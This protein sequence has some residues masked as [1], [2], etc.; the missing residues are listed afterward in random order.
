MFLISIAVYLIVSKPPKFMSSQ[1]KEAAIAQIL[2]R[3]PNLTDNTS[4]GN[5]VYKGKYT[6]FIYPAAAKIYS[7][8]DEGLKRNTSVLETFSFDISNPRLVLNYSVLDRPNLTSI[9]DVPD[10]KLRKIAFSGYVQTQILADGQK[11]LAFEKTTDSSERTVFF[12][13]NSKVYSISIT[14]SSVKEI[15]KLF[16][17]IVMSLKF[18]F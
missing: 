7:Y 14:G 6:S 4:K 10:V 18:S 3:K 16:D 15:D 12:F 13:I 11:G 5:V 1:E 8:R 17:Q 2:G 9:D